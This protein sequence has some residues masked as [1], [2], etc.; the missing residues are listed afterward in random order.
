MMVAGLGNPGRRYAETRHNVGFMTVDELVRRHGLV[1]ASERMGAWCG[2][3]R[4]A[5]RD[6]LLV[7]PQT[8][9]N[10]SGEPIGRLWRYYRFTLEQL[11]VVSDDID[12]PFG[13][14]RLR[15]RGSAG[16]HN[17]L[18]SVFLHVGSQEIARLKIGVGRSA[19]RDARDHVLS[20]F[21]PEERAA[22]AEVLGRAADAVEMV[23]RDG[24]IAAMNAANPQETRQD[25]TRGSGAALRDG[26]LG[27]AMNAAN[28][29]EI[30]Q[31]TAQ[32]GGAASRDVAPNSAMNLPETRGGVGNAPPDA[33]Q[34]PIVEGQN[35]A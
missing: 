1:D 25:T 16:G 4:I 22:L 3:A 10:V 31:D 7:K 12:L 5:G 26:S 23:L 17:G 15:Q 6:V 32:S 35:D 8:F 9:M 14:L 33:A 21:S 13:R 28:A 29:Y 20:S 11:L 30:R 34:M 2:R 27:A 18:R 19:E 24:I